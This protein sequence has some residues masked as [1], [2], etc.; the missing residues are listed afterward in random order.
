MFSIPAMDESGSTEWYLMNLWGQE[1]WRYAAVTGAIFLGY[2][3]GKAVALLF[4]QAEKRAEG[5]E[6]SVLAGVF[7]ALANSLGVLG[8]ALGIKM[9]LLFLQMA[10][11]VEEAATT[12][13][14]VLSVMA[15]GWVAFCLTE[16]PT[17]I[18]RKW[19]D[20]QDSKLTV[21]LVPILRTSLRVAVVVLVLV[22]IAQVVSDKPVSSILAGLGIGGLAFA[23][24]A[25]DSLKHLFGSVVIFADRPFEVGDRLVIE[26]TDGVVEEV[27]FRSTRIRTLEGHLVTVP[28]G[29]LVN[30]SIRN[31][32]K[33][34]HIRRIVN[35]TLTY[36]TPPEKVAR[37]RDI[38]MELLK[39]HEG[40]HAD[41]PP[42]A[43]FNDF[44]AA[45]LNLFVIYWYHPADWWAYNDF[46]EKW[47][48]EILRRFNEEGIDFA[49]PTQTLYLAG[50]EKRPLKVG[51]EGGS[52]GSLEA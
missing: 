24:A 22:Q 50:D 19:S 52:P 14:S 16:V 35:L 18:Y 17:L 8:L 29:D 6:R 34:P 27:G 31:V 9:G 21:M 13:S 51:I 49:F 25:Q 44:N 43:Y 48:S 32:S 37:A 39:D 26:S 30:K 5:R 36:D 10:P 2:L 45:S 33:R 15:V 42:R 41:F 46:S 3:V 20:R 23:L 12:I 1:A 28:N 7:S 4:R 11:R 47:N 40:M 38:V